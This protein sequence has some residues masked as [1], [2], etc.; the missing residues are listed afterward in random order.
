M[1][2]S[3]QSLLYRMYSDAGE[4][5]LRQRRLQ[6]AQRRVQEVQD[7]LRASGDILKIPPGFGRCQ[8]A[9][10]Q[11]WPLVL[12]RNIDGVVYSVFIDPNTQLAVRF[13]KHSR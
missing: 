8:D 5:A 13:R 7:R 6:N 10:D 11:S 12:E 3:T 2:A 1:G 9:V 4:H